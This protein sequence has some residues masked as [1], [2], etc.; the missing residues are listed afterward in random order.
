[1]VDSHFT[2]GAYRARIKD[3][4]IDMVLQAM[5]EYHFNPRYCITVEFISKQGVSKKIDENIKHFHN[6]S[7]SFINSRRTYTDTPGIV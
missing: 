5:K 3:A 2:T 4:C 6:V 7:C 1:M